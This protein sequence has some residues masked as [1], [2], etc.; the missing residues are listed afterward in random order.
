MGLKTTICHLTSVHPALDI[1]IFYKECRSLAAA[2]YDVALVVRNHPS[3]LRDGVRIICAEKKNRTRLGRMTFG[4]ARVVWAGLRTRAKV[5]HMHDPELIPFGLA[6]KLLG[7]RVIYDAHE[8]IEKQIQ[9]KEYI[10]ASARSVL[11]FAVRIVQKMILPV[12]D[13]VVVATPA[14]ARVMR[15]YNSKNHVVCNFP[16]LEELADLKIEREKIEKSV[17]Y[18]GGITRFRGACEMVEAVGRVGGKLFLA[19]EIVGQDLNEELKSSPGWRN[20]DYKGI[21]GR[22]GIR[23][24]LS[25]AQ[26]GLVLLYPVPNHLEALPNKM[27]EYM[28]AGLP[29]ISSDFPIFH[30]LIGEECCLFVDPMNVDQIVAAIQWIFDHPE[31]ALKMGQRGR[32][33]V[34]SKYNWGF[35][36]EKLIRMYVDILG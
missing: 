16:L 1:R 14:I 19:G 23:E 31:E 8:D 36:K 29:V 17:C 32:D 34:L 27:F 24:V 2:G 7:K 6:L 4:A 18:V 3:E 22:G 5:F 11:S 12:F 26:A 10:P 15:R 33:L 20:V 21:V 25:K 28:A 35:E 9:G 30:E 13:S